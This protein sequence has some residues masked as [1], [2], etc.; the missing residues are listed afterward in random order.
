MKFAVLN[1]RAVVV[2]GDGVVD[3]AGASDGRFGP[4]PADCYER[5]GELRAWAAASL[6]GARHDPLPSPSDFGPPTPRPRQVFGIGVN[7]ADHAAEAGMISP[8]DPMV[9]GKFA[10]CIAAPGDPLVVSVPT[11]DWEAELVVVIAAAA[12]NLAPGDAWSAIAGLTIGQDISDRTLQM[13]GNNPQFGLAKSRP[14][15]GPIGPWLVT[16]DEFDDPDDLAISCTVNG[17]AGPAVPD[18]AHDPRGARADLL[19][20]RHRRPATR[21]RDLHRHPRRCRVHQATTALSRARRRARLLDPGHRR[22]PHRDGRAARGG[23]R[24]DDRRRFA[25]ALPDL[26]A[27]IGRRLGDGVSG[28]GLG[29]RNRSGV[30]GARLDRAAHPSARR[31]H[32]QPLRR[33][34]RNPGSEG[35]RPGGRRPRRRPGRKRCTTWCSARRTRTTTP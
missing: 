30:R 5:W 26:R 24:L 13:A 29:R 2:D 18:V 6:A 35:S 20:Q 19:P 23:G 12:R 32:R 27:G 4:D 7:Y 25:T 28:R 33:R 16:P 10:S 14:G 11:V 15:Y 3:V 34:T 17:E 22:T 31:A 8:D 9:F 1:G 21:R